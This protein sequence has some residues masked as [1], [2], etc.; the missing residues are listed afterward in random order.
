MS[1]LYTDLIQLHKFLFQYKEA[2]IKI[3][4]IHSSLILQ[5]E[6]TVAAFKVIENK[7]LDYGAF[8]YLFNFCLTQ[9]EI[10]GNIAKETNELKNVN[11]INNNNNV[12][13]GALEE[14][15][16]ETILQISDD[17]DMNV[18]NNNAPMNNVNGNINITSLVDSED[19]DIDATNNNA[20]NAVFKDLQAP[21]II[22][23][24]DDDDDIHNGK[25][26]MDINTNYINSNTGDR[27][28]MQNEFEFNY[29]FDDSRNNNN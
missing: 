27:F 20:N 11:N 26:E 25:E 7:G 9:C 22:E 15:K 2:S 1:N 4:I 23:I 12:G 18:G 29:D 10:I 21:T 8:E 17:D 13:V 6:Q 16:N 14:Q 3:K 19:D 28:E 24:S 5:T